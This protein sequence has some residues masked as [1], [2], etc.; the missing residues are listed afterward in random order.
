M[1]LYSVFN[2]FNDQITQV[3]VTFD[4]YYG[5]NSIK[6]ASHRKQSGRRRPIRKMITGPEVPLP[7]VCDQCIALDDNKSDLASFLSSGLLDRAKTL[8]PGSTIV[9]GE[10]CMGNVNEQTSS[11]NAD[12]LSVE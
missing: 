6:N 2:Y 4:R 8:P 11:F 10:G 9:T 3:D 12:Y 5:G 7:Q 1:F